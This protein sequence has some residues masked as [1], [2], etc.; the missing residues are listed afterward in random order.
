MYKIAIFLLLIS[1]CI[2][3]QEIAGNVSL[4]NVGESA[5]AIAEPVRSSP[6]SQPASA[7]TSQN[8]GSRWFGRVGFVNAV[9]HSGATISADGVVIPAASAIVSNNAS[10]TFDI[11]RDITKNISAQLMVGIPPKPTITAKGTVAALGELGAV[12]YGPAILSGYYK[13]RRFGA[14]QPYAGAGA[15]YAI[16]LKEHDA[17]VSDLH[18]RN[19]FGFVLQ[20]GAEYNLKRNWSV[21]GD[22]KEVWLAVDAHGQI[23]GVAPVT[24][25]VKLNPSLVSVGIKY[26]FGGHGSL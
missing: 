16:I 8:E 17:S 5:A 3:A 4:Q 22:F 25:H 18:V 14:F 9:Y 13:M 19:N 21:F 1:G 6:P 23:A 24:A 7:Q 11:G 2:Q 20:G 10:V 26:R 12:R 15:A